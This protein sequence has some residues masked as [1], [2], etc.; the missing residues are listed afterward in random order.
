MAFS[1]EHQQILEAVQN[2][3]TLMFDLAS[4]KAT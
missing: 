3:Q 2:V 1:P 4:E